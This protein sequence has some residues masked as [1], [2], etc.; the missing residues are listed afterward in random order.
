MIGVCLVTRWCLARLV[1]SCYNTDV[2]LVEG[3]LLS[4]LLDSRYWKDLIPPA[5][6]SRP[7]DLEAPP[8]RTY[9]PPEQALLTWGWDLDEAGSIRR[10]KTAACGCRSFRNSSNCNRSLKLTHLLR[11]RHLAFSSCFHE[12]CLETRTYTL[13]TGVPSRGTRGSQLCKIAGGVEIAILDQRRTL[14]RRTSVQIGAAS[15]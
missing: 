11:E 12:N 4:L 8:P 13:S 10:R 14:R 5:I 6:P 1:G 2:K 7:A 9:G 3:G 15:L